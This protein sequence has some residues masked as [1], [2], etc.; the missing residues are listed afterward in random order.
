MKKHVTFDTRI[1]TINVCL[2][3]QEEMI[4]EGD[5]VNE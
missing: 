1:P 3:L 5:V 4:E 2:Q